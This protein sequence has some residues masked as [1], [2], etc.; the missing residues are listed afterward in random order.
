MAREV[1]VD[2]ASHSPQV[3]PILD[4]LAE[5]LADLRPASRRC[6][7][8]PR[9]WPDPRDAAVLRRR[10]TGWTTCARMVRFSAAVQAALEDGYRVFART[11]PAP[12]ADPRRRADRQQHRH[13][14]GG[15][16]RHAAR[17]GPCRTGCWSFVS[18]L[19]SRRRRGGFRRA[20]SRRAAWSTCRCRPGHTVTCCSTATTQDRGHGDQ[21]RRAP[22]ARCA[23]PAGRGARAPRLAVR[24]RDDRH[25]VAGRPP[26]PQR[27]RP[28]RRRLLRDGAG[29]RRAALRRRAPRSATS[30]S[31]D[32]LLLDET[33][34]IDRGRRPCEAP[35]VAT[36][37]VRPDED[38][39][40][41][42]RATAHAAVRR[43]DRPAGPPR[44]RRAAGRSPEHVERQRDSRRHFAARGIEYG[45]AFTGLGGVAP[46]PTRATWWARWR[47]PAEIRAQ[48]S[49]YA[50]HPAVLDACFQTVGAQFLPAAARP[51][52]CCCRW[53]S[54]PA[55][56]RLRPRRS[57]T[58]TPGSPR[59]TRPRSRPIWRSSTS[60]ATSSWKSADCAWA[61]ALPRPPSATG[62]C[63]NGCSP[64]TGSRIRRRPTA[65]GAGDW[66][67]ITTGDAE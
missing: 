47:C 36:F 6:P 52:R 60:A 25:A 22:A 11:V 66:L 58:A 29:G 55:Q 62:C 33:H 61:A 18:D 26:G 20:L 56:L 38:G 15:A 34:R 50:I 28:S 54:A 24:R 12:A 48:Q 35:G 4:E 2:V 7:T 49:G 13:A 8:T 14:G 53:A 1:A 67:V 45:P 42:R 40:Q 39:E 27:R 51:G 3:D 19:H 5:A 21:R 17:T 9:R 37:S 64:S 16:G 59:R 46:T 57:V 30:A 31:S 23:R 44:Y 10:R 43:A 41:V 63:P 65:A 32:L